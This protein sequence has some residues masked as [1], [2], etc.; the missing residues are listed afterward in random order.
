MNMFTKAYEEI[1][2][3]L[4]I[5]RRPSNNSAYNDLLLDYSWILSNRNKSTGIGWHTY[6]KAGENVWL[7]SCI[8][9]YINEVRN[10][11]FEIKSPDESHQNMG[12]VNYL[13]GLFNN[14]MGN[15]SQDTYATYQSAMWHSLLLLGDAFSE[16]I[17]DSEYN[18]VPIGFK[19]I[20]TE[21]MYYYEDTD[22]WGFINNGYRFE[23]EEIIH[24]KE[25]GIRGSVWGESPVDVLAR[26]LTLDILGRNF[27]KEILERKGLDPSGV[28]EYDKDLNDTAYNSEITRL[29]TMANSTKRRGTMVLR[30][31]KFNKV[32]I[33]QE[34]ME[35]SKLSADIRDR[36][37]AV[38]G[39]P[40]A[41]VSIIETASIDLGSGQTQDKQFKKTFN[42]KAKL[43]EDA[44]N[45]VLGRSAFREFFKYNE[46]DIEDRLVKAQIDD[47][48]L[49]NGTSTI[50]EIRASYGQPPLLDA[51]Y[52]YINNTQKHLNFYKNALHREGV[53]D[54][55]KI[56]YGQ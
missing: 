39:V 5:L 14:P 36:I 30:G 25:P 18:N 49:G 16:V 7:R 47:I 26:D 52:D 37:L 19:H 28:I 13:T 45:K 40:P 20:P 10:L 38:M 41:K 48:R 34:D 11:G 12:R 50:N 51:E 43:F 6:Y 22:Q 55:N 35:Y 3:K 23:A 15:Y 31:A 29:Q 33:T 24:I 1:K 56:K 2:N 17:Y 21:L 53:L 32:G 44:F 46:L 42:G 27:T 4:P 8:N 54:Y 9:V